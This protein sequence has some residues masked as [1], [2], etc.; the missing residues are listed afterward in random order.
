MIYKL[1]YIVLHNIAEMRKM[2]DLKTK[3]FGHSSIS[4]IIYNDHRNITEKTARM[5][6]GNLIE[7]GADVDISDTKGTS[8]KT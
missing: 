8:I 1:V 2:L 4:S 6:I 5:S 7:A 3:A